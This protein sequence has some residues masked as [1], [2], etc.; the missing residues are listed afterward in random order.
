VGIYVGIV[1]RWLCHLKLPFYVCFALPFGT[2]P[3]QFVSLTSFFCK[4]NHYFSKI[5]KTLKI[6]PIPIVSE[7][8][9]RNQAKPPA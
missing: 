1:G 4:A 3:C 2:N 7:K 6:K 8:P 9:N 5:E